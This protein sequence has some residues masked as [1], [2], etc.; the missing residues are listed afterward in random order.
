MGK[1]GNFDTGTGELAPRTGEFLAGVLALSRISRVTVALESGHGAGPA[2]LSAARLT[3][4]A[5][6][7]VFFDR[8]RGDP[9]ADLAA[10]LF[11]PDPDLGPA[12]GESLARGLRTLQ[13]RERRSFLVIFDRFDEYLAQQADQPHIATFD[14]AF[15]QTA[16]DGEL[17]VHFLLVMDEAAEPLLARFQNAIP[18]IGDGCLRM[19]AGGGA[20]SQDDVPA[21]DSSRASRRDRS[22]GMLLE[23]LTTV[24]PVGTAAASRPDDVRPVTDIRPAGDGQL[25]DN[26]TPA[27]D[28]QPVV[29][30]A[31]VDTT[32]VNEAAPVRHEPIFAMSEP[33]F[34]PLPA[35]SGNTPAAFIAGSQAVKPTMQDSMAP[36]PSTRRGKALTA[37]MVTVM[38]VGA[39]LYA[40]NQRS[41][42]P[43][44]APPAT[45]AKA[46]NPAAGSGAAAPA[47][48]RPD[49]Q[50]AASPPPVLQP[51]PALA[52]ATPVPAPAPVKPAATTATN[53]AVAVTPPT[54]YV[55]VRS[56]RE[57]DRM[58]ALART[59]SGKGIR[60]V[61]VK[62]MNKGPSV[63]DLRYFRDEDKETALTVQ[64]AMVSAGVPISRLSR[65]NGYE[66]STRPGHFEAWLGGDKTAEPVRRR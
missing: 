21:P 3:A 62:V 17:D 61:D 26:P 25:A 55:H 46:A 41:P 51:A 63:A 45:T 33:A 20:D 39:G 65:M 53:P 8:W 37:I 24:A 14:R 47:V 6:T 31:A 60:V 2:L 40:Y 43:A 18:G 57:R 66:G 42:G 59:L 1:S 29:D 7:C 48:P 27:H 44:A 16:N 28:Y 32:A 22:F 52:A 56:Q 35:E 34:A 9:L 13:T 38:A 19:P 50:Q 58:Q 10:T 12:A 49:P 23:R 15:V 11:D 36:A 4:H 30:A 54:V 5:E 64:K